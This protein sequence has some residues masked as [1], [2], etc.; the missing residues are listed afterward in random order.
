[1]VANLLLFREWLCHQNLKPQMWKL[2]V[3][4]Q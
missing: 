2:N 3:E 4:T 1:V